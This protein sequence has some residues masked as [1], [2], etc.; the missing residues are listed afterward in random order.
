MG[1]VIDVLKLVFHNMGIDLGGGDIRV[2][3]HLLNGVQ[4]RAVFQKMHC[5]TMS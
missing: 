5:K 2:T 3:Q 1:L 4:V